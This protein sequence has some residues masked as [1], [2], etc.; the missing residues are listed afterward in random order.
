MIDVI[1]ILIS[2]FVG[3]FFGILI[4]FSLYIMYMGFRNEK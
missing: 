4:G 3:V 1:D 2:F